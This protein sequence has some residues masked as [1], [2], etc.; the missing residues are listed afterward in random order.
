MTTHGYAVFGMRCG[1]CA[2]AVT[3][4]P[5]PLDGVTDVQGGDTSTVTSPAPNPWPGPGAAALDDPV[6]VGSSFLVVVNALM[7]KRLYL[8]AEPSRPEPAQAEKL[9]T[10]RTRSVNWHRGRRP[11]QQR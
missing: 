4:G 5:E 11:R 9:E 2:G 6:N 10:T 8:P 7:L 1:H 3:S